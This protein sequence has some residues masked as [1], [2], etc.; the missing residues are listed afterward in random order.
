MGMKKIASS[1]F[2]LNDDTENC[3]FFAWSIW[4]YDDLPS[5]YPDLEIEMHIQGHS[6]CVWTDLKPELSRNVFKSLEAIATHF[7]NLR[8]TSR[9]VVENY[10]EAREGEE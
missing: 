9:K 7:A 4:A 3:D 8:E 5:S 6:I 10:L 1:R 2:W